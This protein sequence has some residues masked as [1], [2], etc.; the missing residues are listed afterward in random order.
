[1]IEEKVNVKII[2]PFGPSIAITKIPNQI[3][4][5]LNNYFETSNK[6][7]EKIKK[8]N[9]GDKLAGAV[10]Q[11]IKID[12]EFSKECGWTSFLEQTTQ[13]YVQFLTQ[14]KIS[15]FS[16]I[17]TW[18]VS[19]FK[20]EYNPTH[21]HGGH[22]SGA[23]Y[24]KVPNTLGTNY[25]DKKHTLNHNGFLQLIH[26]SRQFL[27]NSMFNIKPELGNFYLFPNY[28]MHTVFPFKDTDQ[29]RRCVSFNAEIDKEIYNVYEN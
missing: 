29:E 1:M 2:N 9:H 18:I 24:L 6:N 4:V 26:G 28:L 15:K 12:H 25:Q 21:W 13:V 7:K 5:K 16:L 22:I 27:S 10:T 17:D 19:Q 14:R 20:H 3:L 11:E 8:L 23:G